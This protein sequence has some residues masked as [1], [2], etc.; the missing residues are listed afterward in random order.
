[1]GTTEVNIV[2]KA[3][4]VAHQTSLED[5]KEQVAKILNSLSEDIIQ[6]LT[7]WQYI[8]DALSL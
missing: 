6:S 2:E 8:L 1:M 3:F 7:G 5:V 4:W